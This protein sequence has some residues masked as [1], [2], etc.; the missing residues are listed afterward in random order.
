MRG[1]LVTG[2]II[3]IVIVLTILVMLLGC[4]AKLKS[5]RT[6]NSPPVINDVI[7]PEQVVV[8]LKAE[9][10]D[11]DGD[12]LTYLWEVDRGEIDSKTKRTVKWKL[13]SDARSATFTV[14]ASD[15]VNESVS[16]TRTIKVN[17]K[18]VAPVIKRI[19]VPESV[20]AGS[21]IQLQAEVIDP[22]G[23]SFTF[24]WSTEVGPLSLTDSET[25]KW[26]APV[27]GAVVPVE[28]SV[29]DGINEPTVK[30]TTISVVGFPLIVAGEQAAGIRLGDP[31][32][33]VKALYGE[34][35]PFHGDISFFSYHSMRVSGSI[36]GINLVE[37]LFVGKPNKSKTA[38]GVG[39]GSDREQVEKEFGPAEEIKEDEDRIV[40]WYWKKGIS[41]DYGEDSKVKSIHI[42]KPH[43]WR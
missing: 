17:L 14:Y 32:E 36:D 15:G 25:P 23:D 5:D 40:H 38:G 9:G 8:E 11:I 39:I 3:H 2:P 16:M 31:F 35:D 41:F 29:S 6:G 18:N 13:P 1:K 24:N 28:L 7:V 21:T 30:S 33:K 12:K 34:P 43:R 27:E 26:T 37:S 42:L 22:D 19:I 10:H 20:I 4:G